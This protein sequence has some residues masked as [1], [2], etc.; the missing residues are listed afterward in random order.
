LFLQA[1]D[2]AGREVPMKRSVVGGAVEQSL[3]RAEL[4]AGGLEVSGVDRLEKGAAGGTDATLD[5][6]VPLALLD[7]L[8][9]AFSGG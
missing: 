2:L 9:H 8:A 7:I 6:A 3:G 5:D 4:A 1:A